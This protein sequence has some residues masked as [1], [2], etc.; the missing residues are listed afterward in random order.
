MGYGSTSYNRTVTAPYGGF[1]KTV[2]GLAPFVRFYVAT[3]W[4][5]VNACALPYNL[6]KT[7]VTY[8]RYTK[9][10]LTLVGNY[11]KNRLTNIPL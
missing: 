1:H 4:A 6:P 11:F 2:F 5:G 7:S 9:W 10:A 3:F 8:L